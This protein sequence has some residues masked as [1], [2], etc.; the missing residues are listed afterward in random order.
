MLT[1]KDAVI[2]TVTEELRKERPDWSR[3]IIALNSQL[4]HEGRELV[5]IPAHKGL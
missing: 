3:I 2:H 5:T 4:K 1:G